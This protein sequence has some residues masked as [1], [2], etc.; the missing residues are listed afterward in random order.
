MGVGKQLVL[1]PFVNQLSPVSPAVMYEVTAA[2]YLML[3][4]HEFR[5]LVDEGAIICRNHPG[6][7]RRIYLKADL[8]DYLNRLPPCKIGGGRVHP[9]FD[10]RGDQGD[11]S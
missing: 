11:R 2:K 3:G 7:K 10:D 6:R 4:I 5:K 8:D 9:G 1:M